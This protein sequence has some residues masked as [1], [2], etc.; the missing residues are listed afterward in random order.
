MLSVNRVTR[1]Q[2]YD[3]ELFETCEEAEAHNKELIENAAIPFDDFFVRMTRMVSPFVQ[4]IPIS[5]MKI[6]VF[7]M[8]K[9]KLERN[10]LRCI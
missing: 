1:Y 4:M 9:Q 10:F 3:G 6:Y 2:A 7:S 8:L 5:V